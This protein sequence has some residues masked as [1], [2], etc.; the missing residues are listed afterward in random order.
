MEI[1][2]AAFS[3]AGEPVGL[4]DNVTAPASVAAIADQRPPYAPG[5]LVAICQDDAHQTNAP[6]NFAT[7]IQ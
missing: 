3:L 1:L 4:G 2:M 6:S 7:S 5:L